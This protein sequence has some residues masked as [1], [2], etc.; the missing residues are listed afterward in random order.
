MALEKPLRMDAD[1]FIEW[2]MHQ[3]E[4]QR[5]EPHAGEVVAMAPERIVRAEA[6]AAVW[7]ALRDAIRVAGLDC[8]AFPD[9]VSVRIDDATTYEPDASVRCGPCLPGKAIEFDDPVIVVEVVSPSSRACSAGAT[10]KAYFRLPRVRH[11]LIVA[12]DPPA[13]IHHARESET[14]IR[15]R[16]VREGEIALDPPGLAIAV[17][18]IFADL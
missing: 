18:A 6:K 14:A 16:I 3:P 11:Y 8:R 15:T 9:G 1:T 7:S 4:G 2:A 13:V 12:I 17:D 5:Y 10:L